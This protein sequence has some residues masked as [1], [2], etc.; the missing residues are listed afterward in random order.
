MRDD[1][2]ELE[3]V[4]VD[5][6]VEYEICEVKLDGLMVDWFSSGDEDEHVNA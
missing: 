1:L 5:W 2:M 3:V 4:L 6:N